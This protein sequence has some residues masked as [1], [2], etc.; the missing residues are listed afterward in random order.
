MTQGKTMQVIVYSKVRLFSEALA[1]WLQTFNEISI[2]KPCCQLKNL[3]QRTKTLHPDIVLFDICDEHSLHEAQTISNLYPNQR[4]LALALP[5]VAESVIAC[6]DAGFNGYFPRDASLEQ[7]YPIMEKT[8]SDE[9]T[10]TP[11]IAASLM[12]ELHRRQESVGK[13]SPTKPLTHRECEVLE[14]LGYGMCNKEIARVLK[15]SVATV[16][17]HLHNIFSKLHVRGRTEAVAMLKES[18][19]IAKKSA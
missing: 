6:V 4:M 12:K 15:I 5:E 18:P 16:K 10:C 19:W 3:I 13:H 8:I 14:Q 2:V 7:L 1:G 17:N 11:Q 9:C